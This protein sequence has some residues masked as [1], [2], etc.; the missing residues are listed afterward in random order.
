MATLDDF[1]ADFPGVLDVPETS[2][3]PV[4]LLSFEFLLVQVFLDRIQSPPR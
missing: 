4:I 1:L 2:T 3:D